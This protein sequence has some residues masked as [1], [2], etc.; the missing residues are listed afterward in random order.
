MK[1]KKPPRKLIGITDEAY[2]RLMQIGDDSYSMTDRI[3][4]LL[5]KQPKKPT[6][7]PIPY[8]VA[9]ASVIDNMR[10]TKTDDGA[11]INRPEVMKNVPEHLIQLGWD[12]VHPELFEDI[13]KHK[14]PIKRFLDNVIKSLLRDGITS[15]FPLDPREYSELDNHELTYYR[16]NPNQSFSDIKSHL[17]KTYLMTAADYLATY[18]DDAYTIRLTKE[19][20]R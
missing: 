10:E 20:V 11:F 17:N 6:P 16:I 13:I 14:S 15:K 1:E 18:E 9:Q 2:Q 12:T 3:N 7:N 5:G 19:Y 8:A 4:Y